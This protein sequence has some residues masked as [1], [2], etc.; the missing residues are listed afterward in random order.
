M[1]NFSC[2]L[3]EPLLICTKVSRE[4]N[5]AYFL[6]C[7]NPADIATKRL[8][9]IKLQKYEHYES[10]LKTKKYNWLSLGYYFDGEY[11]MQK[12]MNN[13]KMKKLSQRLLKKFKWKF[14]RSTEMLRLLRTAWSRKFINF[15]VKKNNVYLPNKTP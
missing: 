14:I 7:Y 12:R 1:T 13:M 4:N 8:F 10:Q 5:K 11:G 3:P 9:S 15:I 6:F 2:M